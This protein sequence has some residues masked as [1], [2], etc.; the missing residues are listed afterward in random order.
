[1][2][3]VQISIE[4]IVGTA[5]DHDS[6]PIARCMVTKIRFHRHGPIRSQM[7]R[8][9]PAG[10][11]EFHGCRCQTVKLFLHKRMDSLSASS[12][13]LRSGPAHHATI[14][15]D[16]EAARGYCVGSPVPWARW[17]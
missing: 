7:K 16:S 8:L 3:K 9:M 1:M 17:S 5:N 2:D 6:P 10:H 13:Q 11:H 12:Y 4:R 15:M 14:G